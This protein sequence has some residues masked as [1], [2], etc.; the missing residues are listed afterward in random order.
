MIPGT[1]HLYE[2]D[3]RQSAPPSY[4][5]ASDWGN[6]VTRAA[7]M[8]PGRVLRMRRITKLNRPQRARGTKEQ[9]R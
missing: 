7:T 6:A 8:F 3:N 2:L 4:F 9:A 1:L 5:L